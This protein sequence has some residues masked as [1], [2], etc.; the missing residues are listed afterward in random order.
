[1]SNALPP[2]HD[3]DAEAAVLSTVLI[4]E[5]AFD[6][7]R[8]IVAEGAAFFSVP[9]RML[10][11]AVGKLADAGDKIDAITVSRKLRDDD[12]L[13]QVGG[14]SYISQI[15]NATPA[16][17]N[18]IEHAEIV[19]ERWRLRLAISNAL[20]IAA[21][22]RSGDFSNVQSLLETATDAFAAIAH[23]QQRADIFHVRELLAHTHKELQSAKEQPENAHVGVTTGFVDLDRK[24]AGYQP[25]ALYV[26]AGRPGMGKTAAAVN[27]AVCASDP[28]NSATVAFFSL[29]MGKE[30]VAERIIAAEAKIDLSYVRKIR[31]VRGE[32]WSKIATVVSDVSRHNLW[33]D[34]TPSIT[35]PELRA[36]IRRVNARAK[37][38]SA[39]PLAVVFVDYL[40]LMSTPARKYDNRTREQEVAEIA[41][42]LKALAK[43]E[44]VAVVALAQLNRAVEART[45]K[46]PQLSDLRESGSIEAEADCVV[47]THR[48]E[49]YQQDPDPEIV[50]IAE[51]IIAKQRNGPLGDVRVRFTKEW[52]RFDNLA[53]DLPDD[54]Y[55]A[56][57]D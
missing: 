38:Q 25:G 53:P 32:D 23:Q 15:I 45:I 52:A 48:A 24:V 50:G 14:T 13:Q 44:R 7:V 6:Q 31:R 39:P 54:S 28:R 4:Q 36:K 19:R 43:N 27:S 40:Q 46:R 20:D 22:A 11:E 35:V 56:Y 16:V 1:M 17:A 57:F 2:P 51:F 10:F 18:V 34:D 8:T 42:G 3:L 41:Q 21:A 30:Q 55:D 37:E 12:R 26:L 29:E 49:Y 47:F 9:N 33:V 5:G